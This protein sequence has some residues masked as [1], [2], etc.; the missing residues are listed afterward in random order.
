[1]EIARKVFESWHEALVKVGMGL[2]LAVLLVLFAG[3]RRTSPLGAKLR[4][5][6]PSVAIPSGLAVNGL[7]PHHPTS[8]WHYGM[9]EKII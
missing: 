1:M 7:N 8:L 5:W 3:Y 4:R 9:T 2:C 6:I